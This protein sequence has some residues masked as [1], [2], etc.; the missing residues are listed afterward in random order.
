MNNELKKSRQY[1]RSRNELNQTGK[2][3]IRRWNEKIQ[4]DVSGTVI[5]TPVFIPLMLT[6]KA[7]VLTAIPINNGRWQMIC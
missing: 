1:F 7:L 5:R 3:S 4:M 2:S 6:S